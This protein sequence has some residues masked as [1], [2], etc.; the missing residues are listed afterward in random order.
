MRI[1]GRRGEIA[2]TTVSPAVIIGSINQ[3]T[4]KMGRDYI[5][6]TS[7]GDVNKTYV[8]GLPDISGSFSGFLDQETG[9]P[10]SGES[11]PLFEAAEGETPVTLRLTPNTNMTDRNWEGPAYLDVSIDVPVSGAA[12]I[13]GNFKASGAWT[14]N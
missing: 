3:F 10:D 5:D 8:P 12:T 1:S 7:F 14:R 11:F 13:S 2:I 9:S 6:V 4:L